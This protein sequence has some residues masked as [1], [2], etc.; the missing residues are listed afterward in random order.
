MKNQAQ[1]HQPVTAETL[2]NY[3]TIF[4][5]TCICL[6]KLKLLKIETNYIVL[7]IDS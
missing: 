5:N 3:H 1:W 2:L 7:K 4:L 6:M